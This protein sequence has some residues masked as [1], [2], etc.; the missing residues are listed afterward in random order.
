MALK[1]TWRIQTKPVRA[2]PQAAKDAIKSA[3]WDIRLGNI[4]IIR[5]KPKLPSFRSTLARI[6]EPAVGAST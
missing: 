2:A 6:I 4:N 1:S 3:R 5:S